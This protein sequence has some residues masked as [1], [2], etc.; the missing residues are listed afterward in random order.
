MTQSVVECPH[1]RISELKKFYIKKKVRRQQ[2][3]FKI[4]ILQKYGCVAEQRELGRIWE[5]IGPRG[6]EGDEGERG[7]FE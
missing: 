3:R 1:Q 7:R 6:N 5:R 2:M 4:K